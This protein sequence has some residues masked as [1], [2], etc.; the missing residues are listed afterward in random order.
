MLNNYQQ[1]KESELPL[2]DLFVIYELNTVQDNPK[3]LTPMETEHLPT[4][5]HY[6]AERV[7]QNVKNTVYLDCQKLDKSNAIV[8]IENIYTSKP[9]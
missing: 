9:L 3:M 6:H 5:L 2:K 8:F 7:S 1:R 4:A